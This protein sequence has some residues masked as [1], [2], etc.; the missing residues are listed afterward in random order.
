MPVI[1]NQ[2]IVRKI[3]IM[4]VLLILII[5]PQTGD[6]YTKVL[7]QLKK[8]EELQ[9]K[10]FPNVTY[11][12]TKDESYVLD[13]KPKPFLGSGILERK[14]SLDLDDGFENMWNFRDTYSGW[15]YIR[16]ESG[17]ELEEGDFLNYLINPADGTFELLSEKSFLFGYTNEEPNLCSP[18]LTHNNKAINIKLFGKGFEGGEIW[19][20]NDSSK[21]AIAIGYH[22]PLFKSDNFFF[23]VY[24]GL[25]TFDIK[26]GKIKSS[27][28]YI[29]NKDIWYDEITYVYT[30]GDT[31]W[32]KTEEGSFNI[33]L[34]TLEVSENSFH[35]DGMFVY[36]ENNL[37]VQNG[38]NIFM[39]DY[40]TLKFKKRIQLKDML[41]EYYEGSNCTGKTHYLIHKPIGNYTPITLYHCN[42][43]RLPKNGNGNDKFTYYV[44]WG[45]G[46][47]NI[48]PNYNY[49]TQHFLWDRENPNTLIEI[50]KDSKYSYLQVINDHLLVHTTGSIICYDPITLDRNW[51]IDKSNFQ[52]PEESTIYA[53]D[54]S[55]VLIRD[56][57][58][59]EFL[60][61]KYTQSKAFFYCYDILPE[62]EPVP[63]PEPT[64]EPEPIPE[65]VPEPVPEPEPEPEPTPEPEPAPEPVIPDPITLE[66]QID[67][68]SYIIDGS[69]RIIDAAPVI[70]NGRTLLPARFVTEPLGG[71]VG[72]EATEKKVVCTLGETTVEMWIGKPIAKINGQEVQIDPDNPDVVP[73]IINDRTMVPMRFLA[74]SLGCEVEW[75]ADTKEIILTYTP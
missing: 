33:D 34:K 11:Y 39:Y 41:C 20:I 9:E 23:Y 75:V 74:E 50:Q 12:Q 7:G 5:S 13:W 42:I 36:D 18:I 48:F 37:L 53:I 4:I 61:E 30:I 22:L 51:T 55:G 24:S 3:I 62:P 72:W 47:H 63:E 17:S 67:R 71:D 64:P 40:E 49:V 25:T 26:T 6:G 68:E 65:P 69:E 70:Q 29:P 2:K 43:N 31:V 45:Q 66:F 60:R 44:G 56:F 28:R 10:H 19:E 21:P 27:L 32:I 58:K 57:E 73:T 54:E 14:W 35:D 59:K 38:R 15:L 52:N 46:H 16:K 8:W 1:I